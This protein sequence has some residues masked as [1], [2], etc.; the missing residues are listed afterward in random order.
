VQLFEDVNLDSKN[1]ILHE[2]SESILLNSGDS[3]IHQFTWKLESIKHEHMFII[4]G[5]LPNDEDSSNNSI[6]NS[7]TPGFRQASIIV[8]EIMYSPINGEPEWIEFFNTTDDSININGFT[9]SDI[10][11]TPKIIEIVTNKFISP[12]NYIVVSKDSTIWDYH[13]SIVSPIITIN[14]ANLNNDIDGV[15]IKDT[16]GETIDSIEYKLNWGGSNGS[17]LERVLVSNSSTDSTNWK[18]SSDL[19]LSTP[20][21]KN[22]VT[23]FENDLAI[24]EITTLPE[25]PTL[26]D[27]VFVEVKIKNIGLKN[28]ASYSS[29]IEY[30]MDNVILILDEIEYSD[31]A[32]A[33]SVILQ[34]EHLFKL[35]DSAKI[36]VE[37]KYSL[38]EN[39]SN[40]KTTITLHPG[41][42]RNT[43]II[44]EFMANPKTDEAEWIELYNNYT[45]DIDISNWFVSDLYTTPKPCKI[46]D[47]PL[48]IEVNEFIIITNDTSKFSYKNAEAIEVNFGTLGN[49]EDGIILY[50]F[51]QKVV[52]SLRYDNDWE[53]EKGR[54]LERVLVSDNSTGIYNWLP[55]LSATG[56]TPGLSNSVLETTPADENSIIINE[57]MFAP[58]IDNSEFVE[59]FNPTENDIDIGGW[60]LIINEKD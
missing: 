46:S 30:E 37:L 22:S 57:I 17:S 8:N 56:A 4:K 11:T 25:F 60:E 54:S 33:D 29:K 24:C 53:I 3:L 45:M 13:S 41:A 42:K 35:T 6:E 31:L 10:L 27:D 44:N 48:V 52:D 20:G 47:A 14:F 39:S 43:I 50:D 34:S 9:I 51:N 58:E 2:T 28:V 49:T 1:I 23:P 21:R 18:S 7:I 12:K 26:D 15:V 16:F 19:E 36:F 32:V 59:L 5:V 40:N 38:D 55:S